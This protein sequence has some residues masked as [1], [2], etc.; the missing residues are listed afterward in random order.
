MSTYFEVDTYALISQ[1]AQEG[2]F[3][4]RLHQKKRA[5]E[6]VYGYLA[7]GQYTDHIR[8][9]AQHLT[10]IEVL[11][12]KEITSHR[13]MW[14]DRLKHYQGITAGISTVHDRL[15]ALILP[16]AGQGRSLPAEAGKLL[17]KFARRA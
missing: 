4:G 5:V 9:I 13:K 14:D 6:A 7:G 8:R 2:G 3:A 11:F 12:H 1:R 15:R 16:A 17:P 10:D